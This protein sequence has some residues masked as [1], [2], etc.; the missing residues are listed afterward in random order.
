MPFEIGKNE[1]LLSVK[2]SE[3]SQAL[4]SLIRASRRS[5]WLRVPLLDPLTADSAVCDAIK[6]LAL[7]SQRVDIRVLFDDQEAAI[8]DGHRLI[9]LARRLPSR[10][11]LRQSQDDDRDPQAC[12]GIGDGTGL[13]EAKGWP[14]PVRI[15]LCGHRLPL[16]PRL[17]RDFQA[18]W[19]RGGSNPELRELRL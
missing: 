18:I 1:T 8:R 10:L 9:H 2:H 3:A 15:H 5:L 16:A 14:R 13:F 12:F 11:Q 7:S 17:A 19:E 6:S 4:A